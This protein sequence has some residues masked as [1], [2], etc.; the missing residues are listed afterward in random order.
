MLAVSKPQFP[1]RLVYPIYPRLSASLITSISLGGMWLHSM[2]HK[3]Q[4]EQYRVRDCGFGKCENIWGSWEC[5]CTDGHIN[6]DNDI[7]LPCIDPC[8]QYDCGVGICRM[9]DAAYFCRCFVGQHNNGSQSDP[10]VE[11]T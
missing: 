3:C 9:L 4:V 8:D 11:N 10:C 5:N 2:N 6:T 7:T 1:N